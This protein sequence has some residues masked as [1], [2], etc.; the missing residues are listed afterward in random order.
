MKERNWRSNL[1]SN[2]VLASFCFVLFLRF[3]LTLNPCPQI[4]RML[5]IPKSG[6]GHP[7]NCSPFLTVEYKDHLRS[8][9]TYRYLGPTPSDSH[10]V[11]LWWGQSL[12]ISNRLPGDADASGE[13]CALLLPTDVSPPVVWL[14]MIY[15]FS[16][17]LIQPILFSKI[18]LNYPGICSLTSHPVGPCGF[19]YLKK[20]FIL[21]LCGVGRK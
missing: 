13:W 20:F 7:T 18:A 9:L 10:S 4:Y 1:S 19:T 8:S 2:R 11:G 21:F 5:T 14:L 6:F 12:S 3:C 15:F 17:I 16:P